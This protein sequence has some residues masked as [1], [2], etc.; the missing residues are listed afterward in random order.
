MPRVKVAPS[1]FAADFADMPGAFRLLHDAGADC[2]HYDVMDGRFVPNISFGPKFIEDVS[3]K[4][5]IPG[6]THLMIDLSPGI[7]AY[8]GQKP[9]YIT[10]HYEASAEG[11][12]KY[13]DMITRAGKT[14]GISIKPGTSP[15]TLAPYLDRIGL[16]LIM[17]VEPGFSGQK[18]MPASLGRIETVRKMIGGRDILLQVDGGVCRENYRDVIAAGADFIVI[19]SAFFK[20]KDPAGWVN[21][22]HLIG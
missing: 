7:D 6:D 14:A 9:S 16:I 5:E 8:L 18:F 17:S 11:P 2:V 20:D 19:G 12:D 10:V 21:E 4:T 3:A 15:E 1:I 13:I 22:I